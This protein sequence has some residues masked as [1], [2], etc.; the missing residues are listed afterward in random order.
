MAQLL[1]KHTGMNYSSPVRSVSIKLWLACCAAIFA[2]AISVNAS[3]AVAPTTTITSPTAG[4]VY[5]GDD[6]G[7]PAAVTVSFGAISLSNITIGSFTVTLDGVALTSYTTTGVGTSS[8][9]TALGSV[10][11]TTS[12][13][14]TLAV[15][16]TDANNKSSATQTSTFTVTIA[17]PPPPVVSVNLPSGTSYVYS[18]GGPPLNIN[19]AVSATAGVGNIGALSAVLI[20]PDSSQT[21]ISLS[22]TGVGSSST[23]TGTATLTLSNG[24]LY[25]VQVTTTDGCGSSTGSNA[26]TI[27]VDTVTT[28]ASLPN[29]SVYGRVDCGAPASIP[30]NFAGAS[31]ALPVTSLTATLDGSPIAFTPVGLGTENATGAATLSV[32]A[33]GLHTIVVTTVDSDGNT[34]SGTTTF[35]V[36]VTTSPPPAISISPSDGSLFTYTT[37]N[38]PLAINVSVSATAG[39]ANIT[40]LSAV[41]VNPDSSQTPISLTTAGV[42]SSGVATGT[43]ILNLTAG[44]QYSIQVTATDGCNTSNVAAG[45]NINVI[46]VYPPPTASAVLPNGTAYTRVDCGGPAPV[47]VNFTGASTA[48]PI[49]SLSATLDG[50][51]IAF[52]PVGLGTE[53]ATGT[54]TLNVAAAGLHSIVVTTTDSNG[55]TAAATTFFSV[56]VTTSPAPAVTVTSPLNG[57]IYTYTTGNPALNI[58]VSISATAGYGNIATL[59]AVLVN[60]NSSQVS[61]PLTTTGVG[62]SPSATGSANLSLS[63]GGSY[64]INITVSDGC[65]TATATTSFTINVVT[66]YPPPTACVTLPCGNVYTRVDCAGPDLVKVNFAG[67][68]SALPI[69]S[70]KATLDGSPITFAPSGIGT[71]KATGTATLSVAT[72]GVH[73]VVLTVTDSN[74]GTATSSVTFTIT[75]TSAPPPNVSISSPV[76]GSSYTYS[77]SPLNIPLVFTANA[78]YGTIT[79][80]TATLDGAPITL[81]STGLNTSTATGKATL[82][83]TSCVQHVV[84]VTATDSCG[85]TSSCKTSFTVKPPAVVCIQGCVYF[86]GNNDGCKDQCD[87]GISGCTVN[88]CD[89]K[90]KCI[91]T[92]QCGS[93]GSYSFNEP[94]GTYLVC[95]STPNGLNPT[96]D[97]QH[98]CTTTVTC[99]TCPPTGFFHCWDKV[100]CFKSNGCTTDFWKGN[101]DKARCGNQWGAQVCADKIKSYT[102]TIGSGLALNCFSKLTEDQASCIL[103]SNSCNPKDQLCKQLLAA[104]YNYVSGCYINND[105]EY[106]YLFIYWGECVVQNYNNCGTSYVNFC[107]NWCAAYNQ[108]QGGG[109]VCG[110]DKY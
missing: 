5:T 27:S 100:K 74:G 15:Y 46:T 23:A 57:T 62:S 49:T 59:S 64:T 13:T 58:P 41:L 20:N 60:P 52:T 97:C 17:T 80:I 92:T 40:A 78:S 72:A 35:T 16:A 101:I 25:T 39:Y 9:A 85:A 30:V 83:P 6:C 108:T 63:T 110:Q 105:P 61:I 76:S 1:L 73:T 12:G 8:T 10:T 106:T 87:P 71:E 95:V 107:E 4:A 47:L 68:S 45:F 65:N 29:G 75:V 7:G 3:I 50:S 44:G 94:P 55:G 70:L 86:D 93:D 96:G 89:S 102:C 14:H 103:G 21:P 84:V 48:L 77:G 19:V 43:A 81:T 54:A 18:N 79:A 109:Y 69:A 91:A 36:N 32:T 98:P 90:L 33:A 51:A 82:N 66:N 53:N 2:S 28:G 22:T 104:E 88:L 99:Y 56:E 37:G 34:A 24:G 26:F 67:T 11:F 38:P 31:T 42:G